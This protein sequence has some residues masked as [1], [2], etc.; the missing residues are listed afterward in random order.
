MTSASK[1]AQSASDSPR[2]SLKPAGPGTGSVDGGWWPTSR[3]LAAELPG[4]AAELEERLGRVHSVSYNINAWGPTPRK[5]DLD[6]WAV[7]LSGYR[8][9]NRDTVDVV[10]V[11]RQVTLLV[12]PPEAD[13]QDAKSSM[14]AAGESGNTEDIDALR[15][16]HRSGEPAPV[17]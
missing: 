2:L 5:I 9:Q 16:T 15:S 11:R 6:G 1:T 3:D 8:T 13:P 17:S 12:V 4:V 14:T 7:R 10:G